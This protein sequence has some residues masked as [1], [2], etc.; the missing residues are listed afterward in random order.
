MLLVLAA[1][2]LT[3]L[4]YPDLPARFAIH[5]DV[6]GQP[7]G[8]GT[9]PFAFALPLLMLV[10]G[11]VLPLLAD[12]SLRGFELGQSQRVLVRSSAI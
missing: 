7:N 12:L 1:F 10:L 3:I 2:A 8:Y 5:W 11:T 4:A 9:R 6:H